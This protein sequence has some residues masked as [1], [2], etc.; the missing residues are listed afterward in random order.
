MRRQRTG[1]PWPKMLHFQHEVTPQIIHNV[2]QEKSATNLPPSS[3]PSQPLTATAASP[4]D[5][6]ASSPTST[7]AQPRSAKVSITPPPAER[8]C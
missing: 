4:D 5:P 3:S 1:K 6:N 7:W 2:T 8:P